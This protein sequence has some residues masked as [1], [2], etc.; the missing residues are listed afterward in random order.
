MLERS[1]GR[2]AGEES[3][4]GEVIGNVNHSLPEV[5]GMRKFS[6]LHQAALI[7]QD[8]R[9]PVDDVVS[10]LAVIL[11]LAW[12]YPS[13][14]A[15]RIVHGDEVYVAGDFQKTAWRQTAAFDTHDGQNG[16]IDVVYLSELADGDEG[17]FLESEQDLLEAVASMLA[18]Y[19]ERRQY[20][21]QTRQLARFTSENPNPV[22]RVDAGG[23]LLYANKGAAPL[24]DAWSCAPGKPVPGLWADVVAR[25]LALDVRLT[26]DARAGDT[27][28]VCD[29]VPVAEGGY[30]NVYGRDVTERRQAELALLRSE[31]RF[32]RAFANSPAPSAICTAG[33]GV[34]IDVNDSFLRLF[35]YERSEMIGRTDVEL[36]LW[37]GDGHRE[38]AIGAIDDWGAARDLEVRARRK[39]G[40]IR[41][42]IA[43]LERIEMGGE[44]CVLVLAFDITERKRREQE[45]R[46]LATMA[47]ALRTARTLEEVEAGI[48]Q[49]PLDLLQAE[50]AALSLL[51]EGGAMVVASAAG[52]WEA[53]YGGWPPLDPADMS[54]S[55]CLPL[56]VEGE[57]MGALQFVRR[58]P[59][60]WGDL[61]LLRTLA[62]MAAATLDRVALFERLQAYAGRV[63]QIMESVPDGVVL[64]DDAQRIVLT[65]PVADRYLPLLSDAG[66]GDPLATLAGRPLSEFIYRRAGMPPE[67]SSLEIALEAEGVILFVV[68]RPVTG[69]TA[70]G[71]LV[72]LVR[73][74]TEARQQ[75]AYQQAQER[76]ATVGQLAAG[77]AHDFNNILS[78]IT[79][80]TE[81]LKQRPYLEAGDRRRLQTMIEQSQRAVG[82]IEQLL[83]YSRRS[84]LERRPLH[85][86]AFVREQARL[87]R[88]SL[89]E[90]VALD[91]TSA[92]DNT[93]VRVDAKRI[94]QMLMNLVMNARDAMPG[95]GRLRIDLSTETVTAGTE[96]LPDMSPGRWVRLRVSDDGHGIGP[97][98][99]PHI[100]EPF[101][102]TKEPD[103]GT[104]L[105]LSQVYGIV[106]QHGGYIDVTSQVG[107]GTAFTIYLPSFRPEPVRGPGGAEAEQPATPV[108][109]QQETILVVEDNE[110]TREALC[111]MLE[112]FNYRVLQAADAAQALSLY[113]ERAGE[114]D[115][116]LSDLVLTGRVGGDALYQR[117]AALDEGVK[118][119]LMTG[120]PLQDRG[121]ALLEAGVLAW[122]RKPF[123]MDEVT[124]VVRQ[125]L[126]GA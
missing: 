67:T 11:N 122:L 58:A 35:G 107:A 114:V 112:I 78:V 6:A 48:V 22:L 110:A 9:R 55:F 105:G 47:E 25:A 59:L 117:L 43:S 53:M 30:A 73:D 62:D 82:L 109:G 16:R 66:A 61:P 33:D 69:A 26:L 65:N 101:F 97:D 38:E 70:G 121:R 103:K 95:G 41:H 20:E 39:T 31:E 52:P 37:A 8:P 63:Q 45:Q 2:R 80:Y 12:Q 27:I 123:S 51:K 85:L 118:V 124:A 64:L 24:L 44:R 13:R 32:A 7:L 10:E 54:G 126:Q 76:L 19:L 98:V 72:V 46:A 79:L 94:Q 116:V 68:A 74:V 83:D 23:R 96:P 108:N 50:A 111:D 81:A 75:E 71:G 36:A 57:M 17:P 92:G 77:I 29:V 115:L 49:Q 18:A 40:E 119:V 21:R 1:S 34:F 3:R 125:A 28:Y 4:A 88:V 91:L 89:P 84:I 93:T 15:V 60:G 42:V 106:K 14:T 90:S 86:S 104:G 113:Q 56:R 100:F 99:L 87:L 102:T 5:E 120:Y